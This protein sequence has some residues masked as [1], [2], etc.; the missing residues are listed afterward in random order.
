M[1]PLNNSK[2]PIH[3]ETKGGISSQNDPEISYKEEEVKFFGFSDHDRYF[4]WLIQYG[5]CD[6]EGNATQRVKESCNIKGFSSIPEKSEQATNKYYKNQ[7]SG[8]EQ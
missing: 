8:Y 3:T 4:A 1:I 6:E 2:S 7:Y 5:I